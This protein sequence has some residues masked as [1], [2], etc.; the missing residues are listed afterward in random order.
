MHLYDDKEKAKMA[1]E[2][3]KCKNCIWAKW[4]VPYLVSC[5]FVRCVR[6]SEF[7]EKV[8]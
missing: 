1:Y 6:M 5:P 8:I 7:D 4:Q 2:R 3:H